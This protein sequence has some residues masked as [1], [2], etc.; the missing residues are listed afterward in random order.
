MGREKIERIGGELLSRSFTVSYIY[1][2]ERGK[3]L[4]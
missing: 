1:A 3:K 4:E 2:G